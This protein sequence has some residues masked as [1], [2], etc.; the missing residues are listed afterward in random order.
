MGNP[1]LGQKSAVFVTERATDRAG[2]P[3]FALLNQ[4]G[5]SPRRRSAGDGLRPRV[6]REI[7]AEARVTTRATRGE[8][9][10]VVC[11]SGG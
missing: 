4:R 9:G 1:G 2:A 3:E 5:P 6:N 11:S 10:G 7:S 8:Y